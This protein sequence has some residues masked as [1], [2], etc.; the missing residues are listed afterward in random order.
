MDKYL[1][2]FCLLVGVFSCSNEDMYDDGRN[3]NV[4]F[5]ENQESDIP[6]ISSYNEMYEF[7]GI[8][9]ANVDTGENVNPSLRGDL[10]ISSSKGYTR[11]SVYNKNQK[12]MFDPE[13]A[14]LLGV[15][16]YTVYFARVDRCEIDIKTGGK[17]LFKENSPQCGG[18]P[19]VFSSGGLNFEYIGYS[20][21][22][23]GDPTRLETYL[24]Y[25]DGGFGSAQ[26]GYF[27]RTPETLVW[28]YYLF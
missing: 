5:A 20:I 10:S 21:L 27:P 24:F 2:L 22:N 1:L 8:A 26:R 23:E 13:F 28:N 17:S 7:F 15:A 14:K 6:L 16:P 4:I 12:I 25:F 19:S 3:S 18:V 9:G 11:K